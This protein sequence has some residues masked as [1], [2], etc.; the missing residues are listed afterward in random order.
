MRRLV[1][2]GKCFPELWKEIVS[3]VSDESEMIAAMD[4]WGTRYLGCPGPVE[5]TGRWHVGAFGPHGSSFHGLLEY[6]V[7][8][9]FAGGPA[10][11]SG[12]LAK[13]VWPAGSAVQLHC[14]A[15]ATTH[16]QLP[17]NGAGGLPIQRFDAI[18]RRVRT[19][20]IGSANFPF[21]R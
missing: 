18:V 15:N 16:G 8:Q 2:D 11:R 20:P 6:V 5:L 7:N 4:V 10:Q 12:R 1:I 13:Y 21:P 14:G 9:R 19:L 17:A 3:I